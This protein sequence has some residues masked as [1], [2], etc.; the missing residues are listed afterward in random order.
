[1][2]IYS[3]KGDLEATLV[4]C[5]NMAARLNHVL[6]MQDMEKSFVFHTACHL[7]KCIKIH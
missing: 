4:F 3:K 7:A 2:I 6:E 5:M 1:M